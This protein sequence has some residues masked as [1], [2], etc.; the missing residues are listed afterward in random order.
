MTDKK[1]TCPVI[2][3]MA[4]NDCRKKSQNRYGIVRRSINLQSVRFCV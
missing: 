3:G 2:E 4:A 1:M